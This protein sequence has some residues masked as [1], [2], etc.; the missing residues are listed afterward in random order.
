MKIIAFFALSYILGSIPF[1][2][3][4]ARLCRGVDLRKEGSGNVGATNLYRVC[5][6][7]FGIA[8][9]LLDFLKG[10]LAVFIADKIGGLQGLSVV[11][12]GFLAILGHVFPVFLKFK[13][14]KAVSTSAGVLF[15]FSPLL[16]VLSFLI[17]ALT[18]LKT[19]IVSLSSIIAALFLGVASVLGFYCFNVEKFVVLYCVAVAVAILIFHRENIRRLVKGEER[20]TL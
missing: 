3:I 1:C 16:F 2:F 8:G 4:L 14:G 19:R 11:F 6:L 13:G 17:F 10:F 20:K 15:Y 5:G 12:A 7:P 9:F 18:Y